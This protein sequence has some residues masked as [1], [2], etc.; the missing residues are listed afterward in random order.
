MTVKMKD[1]LNPTI[2]RSVGKLTVYATK[3]EEVGS[4]VH[5][6]ELKAHLGLHS[7][8]GI[9]PSHTQIVRI[10][11]LEEEEKQKYFLKH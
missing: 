3:V 1:E 2:Q 8:N 6:V 7:S 10:H 11:N 4:T 9:L 5:L